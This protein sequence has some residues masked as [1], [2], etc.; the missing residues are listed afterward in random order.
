MLVFLEVS[1]ERYAHKPFKQFRLIAC[2]MGGVRL[3]RSAIAA[4][5]ELLG[6]GEW[7]V[8]AELPQ[9]VDVTD[10]EAQRFAE[11]LCR[12]NFAVV[13]EANWKVRINRDFQEFLARE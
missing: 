4:L 1:S 10:Y 12:F 6:D 3:L 13:D 2:L 7:H 9:Q 11:F 8:L 5:L